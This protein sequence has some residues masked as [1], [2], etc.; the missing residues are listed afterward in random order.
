MSDLSLSV[1]VF[2]FGEK[3]DRCQIENF[4]ESCVLLFVFNLLPCVC[5]FFYFSLG[6]IVVLGLAFALLYCAG[7]VVLGLV[8]ALWYC[9]LFCSAFFVPVSCFVSFSLVL[10]RFV[11]VVA[12][13]CSSPSPVLS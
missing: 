6:G 7:I 1:V 13:Y 11:V 5:V 9:V 12:H 4:V 8:F 10:R 2:S 3:I